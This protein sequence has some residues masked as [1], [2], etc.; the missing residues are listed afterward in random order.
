MADAAAL[1]KAQREARKAK[2][3]A[4]AG[5][6]MKIASAGMDEAP[7]PAA[8]APPAPTKNPEAV[9][10]VPSS[11]SSSNSESVI[12]EVEERTKEREEATAE[13]E[14]VP[15]EG[16]KE[17]AP[18]EEAKEV[19]KEK[20][21]EK[22]L[23]EEK[24]AV[25][26]PPI[27]TPSKASTAPASTSKLPV[28]PSS[29]TPVHATGLRSSVAAKSTPL[30]SSPTPFLPASPPPTITS[31]PTPP[32]KRPTLHLPPLLPTLHALAPLLLAFTLVF[33]SRACSLPDWVEL[34][35]GEGSSGA[36]TTSAGGGALENFLDTGGG[37]EGAEFEGGGV[38]GGVSPSLLHRTPSSQLAAARS[39]GLLLPLIQAA[40]PVP[41]LC[42]AASP[43]LFLMTAKGGLW[44][45]LPVLVLVRFFGDITG[46]VGGYFKPKGIK[47]A[48][49]E[50]E[51]VEG[52][53]FNL[54]RMIG[55]VTSAMTTYRVYT[56]FNADVSLFIVG[57]VLALI[58]V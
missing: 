2:I 16:V 10:P 31:R 18:K 34:S 17:E 50:V 46:V 33:L 36:T 53:K 29:P 52:S 5:N 23:E 24:P 55:G 44:W 7:A 56:D 49:A 38:E 22:D 43:A 19:V 58:I 28:L 54:G 51:L 14:T 47:A 21:K 41:A 27:K 32:V 25:P 35:G 11:S 57:V 45:I 1:A 37:G 9:T 20:E 4:T 6:R 12:E 8:E 15:T 26:L 42:K 39:G 13:K 48:A 40:L 3:L 30:P